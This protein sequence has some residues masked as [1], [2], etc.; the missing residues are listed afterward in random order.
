MNV[1][2]CESDDTTAVCEPEAPQM[3]ETNPSQPPTLTE[4]GLEILGTINMVFES[5]TPLSVVHDD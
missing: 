3:L 2:L 5:R 4:R 1:I